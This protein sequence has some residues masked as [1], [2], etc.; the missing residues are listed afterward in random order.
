LEAIKTEQLERKIAKRIGMA[1]LVIVTISLINSTCST[2][3]LT[4][5]LLFTAGQR[6]LDCGNAI[7][8]T[9]RDYSD[10]LKNNPANELAASSI[11]L[12]HIKR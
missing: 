7:S 3:A 1:I 12:L 4:L 5:L 11:D 10:E 6:I 8:S 2:V 9:A